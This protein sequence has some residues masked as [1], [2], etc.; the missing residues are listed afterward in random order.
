MTIIGLWGKLRPTAA[1]VARDIIGEAA[2]NSV[3]QQVRNAAI[4]LLFRLPKE[5][6]KK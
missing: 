5:A 1:F 3:N 2:R 4:D 6:P